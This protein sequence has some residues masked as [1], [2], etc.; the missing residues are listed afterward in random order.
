M[1]SLLLNLHYIKISLLGLDLL[2][3]KLYKKDASMTGSSTRKNKTL[4]VFSDVDKSPQLIAILRKFRQ[5][6]AEFD[7]ILLGKARN[8]LCAGLD[9]LEIPYTLLAISSKSRIPSGFFILLSR[10]LFLSP[11]AVYAS[12]QFATFIGISSAYL[13]RVPVRVFTRHHSDLHHYY[14]MKHGI[15]VD[16]ISNLLATKI[17]A[18]SNTVKQILILQEKASS[19]KIKVIYNGI[20]LENFQRT[21]QTH[22]RSIIGRASPSDNI[23]IGVVAR[24]TELKGI[25]YTALAFVKLLK[26][27]PNAHLSL[28][29]ARAD[30]YLEVSRILSDVDPSKYIFLESHPD[31][32]GFLNSLDILIHVPIAVNIESFG[33]VYIES[34]AVGISSIFTVS[35]ILNELLDKEKYMQLVPYKDSQA[36]YLAIMKILRGP[37]NQYAKIPKEWI[38]QFNLENMADLYYREI[39]APPSTDY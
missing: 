21:S 30:S 28:V 31:I 7:V 27:F 29:G 17:I 12:G 3:L 38:D 34:L 5:N 37:P 23:N 9:S 18:V 32:P 39:Y 1:T 25:K 22:N 8:T 24:L 4:F 2:L 19:S 11:K 33:L 6:G 20:A 14:S 35:G 26:V 10:I 13:A 15:I 36:I 16:K